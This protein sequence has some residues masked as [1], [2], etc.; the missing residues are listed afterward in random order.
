M[1]GYRLKRDRE[2]EEDPEEKMKQNWDFSSH[3]LQLPKEIKR[4]RR[5]RGELLEIRFFHHQTILSLP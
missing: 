4:V 1:K 3:I 5:R 2:E